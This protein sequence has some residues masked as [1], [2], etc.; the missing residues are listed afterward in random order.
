[1]FETALVHGHKGRA[2]VVLSRVDQ[3]DRADGGVAGTVF[4]WL[5][6][7]VHLEEVI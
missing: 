2:M 5:H 6:S 1:M 4:A 7:S 3:C